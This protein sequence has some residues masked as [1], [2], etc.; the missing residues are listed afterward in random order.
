MPNFQCTFNSGSNQVNFISPTA[1]LRNWLD[2]NLNFKDLR[3]TIQARN[4]PGATTDLTYPLQSPEKEKLELYKLTYPSSGIMH[5]SEMLV[6][7]SGDTLSTAQYIQ[8]GTLQIQSSGVNQLNFANMSLI[9]TIPLMEVGEG[10]ASGRITSTNDDKTLHLGLLVDERFFMANYSA[11]VDSTLG[12]CGTWNDLIAELLQDCIYNCAGLTQDVTVPD[13]DEAYGVPGLFSDLQEL[14]ETNAAIMLEAALMNV[15]MLIIRHINGQYEIKDYGAA[16]DLEIATNYASSSDGG[17]SSTNGESPAIPHVGYCLRAGGSWDRNGRNIWRGDLPASCVFYFPIWDQDYQY[18]YNDIDFEGEDSNAS[19]MDNIC[20]FPPPYGL[21]TLCD[22]NNEDLTGAWKDQWDGLT[23]EKLYHVRS[24]LN[25]INYYTITVTKHN[26]F[27]NNELSEPTGTA[28]GQKIF[29][30]SAKALGSPPNN[31]HFL[32]ELAS[33]LAGD[34]YS[35]K[36]WSA[37][38][39][40]WNL[41][42]PPSGSGWFTYIYTFNDLDCS[43]RII[44]DWL[45]HDVEQLMHDVCG[46][47]SSSSESE[48]S[49]S[50]SE[51]SESSSEESSS[52]ESS[53]EE[54]SSEESSSEESE[55]SSQGCCDCYCVTVSGYL[56]VD[57]PSGAYCENL[58]GQY[59]NDYGTIE[60]NNGNNSWQLTI[61]GESYYW[62]LYSDSD[63]PDGTYEGIGTGTTITIT[64]GECTSSEQSSEQSEESSETSP[65]CYN[66]FGD[67]GV[68]TDVQYILGFDSNG[69]LG[70]VETSSCGE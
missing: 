65:G 37:T 50:E 31:I 21:V 9:C 47:Y 23:G 70:I 11:S 38:N 43:T 19:E 2:H 20:C 1:E 24:P 48:S 13:V 44:G 32:S 63:C 64:C 61:D 41:M 10:Q 7:I 57:D 55:S 6:L 16:S 51:S 25:V 46:S 34:F 58:P 68:I 36:Y 5:W 15:G 56:D 67:L 53:S 39:E 35:R 22:A 8:K 12:C 69:C 26:A 45:N 3:L 14:G 30:E 28:T 60:Y 29:R 33:N 42:I 4:W 54:S 17:A 66:P 59:T 27:L 62:Q 52:E 40:N 49:E 18:T